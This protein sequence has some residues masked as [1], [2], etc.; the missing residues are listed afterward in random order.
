VAARLIAPWSRLKRGKQGR[1]ARRGCD[2]SRYAVLAACTA[3]DHGGWPSPPQAGT[4]TI[5]W[6]GPG[7]GVGEIYSDSDETLLELLNRFGADDWE[8]AGLQDYR[9]GGTGSSYREAA[10]LLTVYALK[11][12]V[13]PGSAGGLDP[14]AV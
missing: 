12:L 1:S 3:H 5:L 7:Q 14:P 13:P 11:R 4:R 6:H 10:R 8:L 9:E 2:T